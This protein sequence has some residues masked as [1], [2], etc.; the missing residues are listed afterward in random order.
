MRVAFPHP[1]PTRNRFAWTGPWIH[2]AT[3]FPAASMAA[4]GDP[5]EAL[6]ASRRV[7]SPQPPLGENQ[8]PKTLSFAPSVAPH[9]SKAVPLGPQARSNSGRAKVAGSF[10]WTCALQSPEGAIR[11]AI[12]TPPL[13]QAAVAFPPAS[14]TTRELS[15][16]PG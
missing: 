16:V 7:E 13:T 8:E 3:A 2:T 9:T 5:A 12:R 15:I 1:E 6:L 14:I 10:T 4:T 11:E